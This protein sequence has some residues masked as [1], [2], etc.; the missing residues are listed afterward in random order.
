MHDNE[1]QEWV[2][3]FE[4]AGKRSL[5]ERLRYAFISTYKPVLDD[6]P[7][8]SFDTMEEYRRWCEEALP[9]WLGYGK[10]V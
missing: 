5:K 6:A 8:R 7:Y 1:W 4:A 3:D 2:R 10:S 9:S